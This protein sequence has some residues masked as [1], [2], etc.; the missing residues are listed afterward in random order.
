M[1]NS[2]NRFEDTLDHLYRFQM[3]LLRWTSRVFNSCRE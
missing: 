3:S 1:L 2:L